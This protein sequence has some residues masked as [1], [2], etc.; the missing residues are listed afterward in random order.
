MRYDRYTHPQNPKLPTPIIAVLTNSPYTSSS[1]I[2]TQI[3]LVISLIRT[4]GR[5]NPMPRGKN[6]GPRE[7]GLAGTDQRPRKRKLAG[8]KQGARHRGR[9]DGPRPQSPNARAPKDLM[10]LRPSSSSSCVTPGAGVRVWRASERERDREARERGDPHTG[11][12]DPHP[13]DPNQWSCSPCV[14]TG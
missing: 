1:W 10:V 13:C 3:A 7:R 11:R 6:H 14:T 4:R 5:R 9:T 2:G 12:C 8:A